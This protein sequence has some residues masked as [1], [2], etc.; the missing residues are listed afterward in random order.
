MTRSRSLPGVRFW[1]ALLLVALGLGSLSAGG[2]TGQVATG[3]HVNLIVINGGINPAVNDYIRESIQRAHAGN[4]RAL[5]I[6]LDTPGGLLSSTRSIVKEMLGAPLPVIVYVAP[7][8]AG[9]GSAGVFITLAANIAAMAPGTNIGAAHPVAGG[10]QEVK[11][12]MGEKIENFT[13]SFSEAIAQ[14]RGRDTE[15]AIQ[16]VRRSISITDKE[17]LEK[18]VI[19]IIAQDVSDLLK[20]AHGRE[21]DVVGTK[22]TLDFDGVSVLRFEMGLKLKVLNVLADP[23]IAYL[24][25][26]AGILGLYMEFS[27]PGALFPGIAGGIALLL[28]LASLQVLPINYAGLLLIGLGLCL[29]VAE[30]FLPSFGL[31]GISGVV[32]LGLGSLLLFDVEGSDLTVDPGIVLAAVGTLSAAV[33]VVTFLVVKSQRRKATLGYE[34]LVGEVGEVRERLDLKGRVFVH[35]EVWRAEGAERLEPGDRIEVVGH[36]GMVL[37][38]KRA[39]ES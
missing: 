34:G 15:F 31:L 24:L 27:N 16:A 3:S 14:Q 32:S 19:D 21:V 8:G 20:Q 22:R 7:S 12:V 10:G 13:A 26:M 38:V 23:N 4:A 1:C 28:A 33:L 35:G 25:M 6:Q 36:D 30:A 39:V 11:G 29:L 5:I 37:K 17:A 2:A 18:R 9:A